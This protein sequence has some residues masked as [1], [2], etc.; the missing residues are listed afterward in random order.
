MTCAVCDVRVFTRP[1]VSSCPK[2]HGASW[3]QSR[4]AGLP[5]T[6]DPHREGSW[7]RYK[8]VLGDSD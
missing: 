6:P 8:N 2:P 4:Q 1:I 5:A 7:G 3:N